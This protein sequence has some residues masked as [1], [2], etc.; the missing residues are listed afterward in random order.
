MAVLVCSQ[1]FVRGSHNIA[2]MFRW[3]RVVV[4]RCVALRCVALRCVALRCVAL[5]CVALRC[6]AL[7]CV[8]LR[9][10]ALRCVALRCVALRCVALRCVALRCVALRCVALRCI[11]LY[12]TVLCR[13]VVG[14][15]DVVDS[16]QRVMFRRPTD[17][18]E[19][20]RLASDGRLRAHTRHGRPAQDRYVVVGVGVVV[21][22]VAV[23]AGVFVVLS[24]CRL[25]V[26]VDFVV[27]SSSYSCIRR[28]A[29]SLSMT[30]KWRTE[31]SH[32]DGTGLSTVQ[33]AELITLNDGSTPTTFLLQATGSRGRNATRTVVRWMACCRNG[34]RGTTAAPRA[35]RARN[36]GHVTA[37]AHLTAASRA[38]DPQ[39]RHAS[40]TRTRVQV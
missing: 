15:V 26:L 2:L 12:R 37:S 36:A 32:F 31:A 19:A 27:L 13:A 9:C 4:L 6:V 11:G 34:E 33:C 24:S 40:A 28:R 3:R 39:C 29:M 17:E 35:D 14:R 25:V 8:A 5:R 18:A 7:R 1:D 23:L 21:G 16:V 22:V 30:R 20:V 38:R 10:V